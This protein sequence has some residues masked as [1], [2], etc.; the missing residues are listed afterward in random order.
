[1]LRG[2]TNLD[3]YF[4]V[5]GASTPNEIGLERAHHVR[6]KA[7]LAAEKKRKMSARTLQYLAGVENEVMA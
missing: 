2:F 6:M 7:A 1:M 4:K 3:S 5:R